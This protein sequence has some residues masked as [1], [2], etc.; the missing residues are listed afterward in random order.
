MKAAGAGAGAALLAELFPGQA[1]AQLE[2]LLPRHEFLHLGFEAGIDRL[3]KEVFQNGKE[4]FYVFL[5]KGRKMGWLNIEEH[6]TFD[7]VQSIDLIPLFND[8]EIE[9]MHFFHTHPF[10]AGVESKTI[11]ERENVKDNVVREAISKR[12]SPLALIPSAADIKMA[13]IITEA[14]RKWK[15]NAIK[16]SLVDPAGV[17]DFELDENHEK[18]KNIKTDK[19]FLQLLGIQLDE[20]QKMFFESE[21]PGIMQ[22]RVRDFQKW[23]QDRWG[24]RITFQPHK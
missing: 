9:E 19:F 23:A 12:K 17:W 4:R 7:Q 1:L 13:L 2:A 3:R 18:I 6:S 21:T 16:F 15:T 5:K 14:S 10:G 20:W 22:K 8:Q 24:I 11:H